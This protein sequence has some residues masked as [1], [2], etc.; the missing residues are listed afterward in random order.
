[1]TVMDVTMGNTRVL[2]AF[3]WRYAFS[4]G[5]R[6][7][8]TSLAIVFGIAAGMMALT[9]ILSL[10]NSLQSELID[11]VR[12]VESFHIQ[13][14]FDDPQKGV[15]ID[16]MVDRIRS[17]EGIQSAVPFFDL[18]ALVQ[19]KTTRRSATM[20][21]RAVPASYWQEQSP[22]TAHAGIVSGQTEANLS[23]VPGTTLARVLALDIGDELTITF[24]RPGKTATLAP[25]TIQS[26]VCGM[27]SSSLP[28]FDGSTAFIDYATFNEYAGNSE[29][30]LGLY[31]ER[32]SV[33]ANQSIMTALRKAFPEG[34]FTSWQEMNDAFYSALLLEKT[35]MYVFLFSIFLILGVNIRNASARLLFQKLRETAML[36]ALGASKRFITAVFVLQGTLL[37]ALGTAFGIATG[38]ILA[39][40]IQVVFGYLDTVQRMFTQQASSLLSYPFAIELRMSEIALAALA[41]LAVAVLNSFLG[42]R[43]MLGIEPL[44]MLHHE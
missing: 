14:F 35:L 22:F 32:N 36:R 9:T 38:V 17:I 44:E 39:R 23:I 18:Q 16:G 28:E 27:Y 43:R 34:R 30:V 11:H 31:L 25:H 12:S 37:A 42:I 21:L 6:H 1:M 5:N 20:R 2:L 15:D 8:K 41:V 4:K 7:R 26:H 40:N 19:T 29:I 10:M 24:L 33:Q 13:A 3:T